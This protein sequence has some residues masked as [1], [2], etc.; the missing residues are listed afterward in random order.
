MEDNDAEKKAKARYFSNR[1]HDKKFLLTNYFQDLKNPNKKNMLENTIKSYIKAINE[2]INSI[3]KDDL[4]NDFYSKFFAEYYSLNEASNEKQNSKKLNTEL[5][6]INLDKK[7]FI[8]KSL[9]KFTNEHI[10]R[11]SKPIA[12]IKY[13]NYNN[14]NKTFNIS[15]IKDNKDDIN[16]IEKINKYNKSRQS[17]SYLL[18]NF[19]KTEDKDFYIK[20]Y[21]LNKSIYNITEEGKIIEKKLINK[22]KKKY[23]SGFKNKYNG[24]MRKNKKILIDINEYINGKGGKKNNMRNNLINKYKIVKI[25]S[26]LKQIDRK[27]KKINQKEKM[28]DIIQDIKRFKEK[29]IIIQDRFRKTDEKFNNLISNSDMI[30]KRILKKFNNNFYYQ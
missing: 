13:Q 3:Q 21:N 19:A 7:N 25:G 23:F 2:G 4:L 30:K 24:L 22:E 10:N 20:D 11:L 18:N 16:N 12:F 27:I 1:S 26:V 14:L 6:P 8:Q 17:I 28:K 29:E 15:K 5:P 9:I